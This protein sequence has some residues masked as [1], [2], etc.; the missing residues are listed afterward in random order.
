MHQPVQI[1]FSAVYT[2]FVN[3][4]YLFGTQS[5]WR[6]GGPAIVYIP[7]IVTENINENAD[8]LRLCW[9]SIFCLHIEVVLKY[10]MLCI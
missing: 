7:P 5:S 8:M 3:F 10:F 9:M 4:S 2:V 1:S 6:Y